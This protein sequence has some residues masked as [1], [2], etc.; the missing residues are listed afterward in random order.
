MKLTRQQKEAIRVHWRHIKLFFSDIDQVVYGKK[1]PEGAC[2][3]LMTYQEA[4]RSF[5]HKTA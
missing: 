1:H 2:G 3:R 4:T 5:P